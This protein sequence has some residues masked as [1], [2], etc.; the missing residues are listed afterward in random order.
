MQYDPQLHHRRSVRLKGHDYAMAGAYFVTVVARDDVCLF[1]DVADEAVHLNDVGRITRA[2]WVYLP[3]HFPRLALDAFVIMPNHI[4]GIITISDD[5]CGGVGAGF[6]RPFTPRHESS[7]HASS[8]TESTGHGAETTDA[9]DADAR[10][11]GAE[12]APLPPRR[13]LGQIV[14]FFKYQSTKR[15]N[16]MRGTPGLHVWQRNYYEHIIRDDE[17]LNRIRQYIL[18]NPG[19]WMFDREDPGGA[20]N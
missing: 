8:H 12:T 13:T 7:Q 14:A 18:E 9:G 2:V 15:I 17:S 6:P 11:K 3:V 16:A 19:R 4:H 5:D 20:A 1:G 10:K